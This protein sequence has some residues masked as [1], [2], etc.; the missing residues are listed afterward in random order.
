M[1]KDTTKNKENL[2]ASKQ[3]INHILFVSSSESWA[4]EGLFLMF[5]F[6]ATQESVSDVRDIIDELKVHLYKETPDFSKDF[7]NYEEKVKRLESWKWE[8]N[9]E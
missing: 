9:N 8:H 1:K 3:I 4:V 6:L 7:D 5:D 2:I